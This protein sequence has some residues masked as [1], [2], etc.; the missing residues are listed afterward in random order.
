MSFCITVSCSLMF[1][2]NL[3]PRWVVQACT[4]CV[5]YFRREKSEPLFI[6]DSRSSQSVCHDTQKLETSPLYKAKHE[7]LIDPFFRTSQSWILG[8]V[9]PFYSRVPERE[10]RAV[11]ALPHVWRRGRSWEDRRAEVLVTSPA[12]VPFERHGFSVSD[13]MLHVNTLLSVGKEFDR[14]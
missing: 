8:S 13:Y 10:F 1:S 4:L 14:K 12:S 7:S 6:T 5:S 3:Y 9:S 11:K 2:L